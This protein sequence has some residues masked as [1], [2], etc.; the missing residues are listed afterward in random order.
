MSLPSY[1]P[2]LEQID[3]WHHGLRVRH[4][5]VVPCRAGCSACCHGPFDISVADTAILIEAV[6]NLE[7][8]LL[9]AVI[10]RART[11]VASM[12]ALQPVWPAP[13][14]I[15]AIGDDRFDM[16]CDSLAQRPCPLLDPAGACLTYPS[17]PMICRIMGMGILSESGNVIE[18]G[19]PIQTDFP[20]YASLPPQP[21]A[22]EIWEEGEEIAKRAAAVQLFGDP[23]QS[24]YETTIAAA[25]VA[26]IGGDSPSE[27]ATPTP[28]FTS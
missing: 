7:P 15:G 5:N 2:L 9:A 12:L 13:F 23:A 6:K 14:D 3:Q 4:P 25:I 17:R 11:D 26:W 10:E 28:P 20:A 21:V 24:E 8:A 22:L 1:L 19:C 16:V 27:P 18:N